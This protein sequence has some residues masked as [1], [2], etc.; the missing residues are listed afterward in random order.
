MTRKRKTTKRRN[1]RGKHLA[2]ATAAMN[3]QYEAILRSERKRGVPL[4]EAKRIAAATVRA[5]AK[6]NPIRR[7]EIKI[8]AVSSLRAFPIHKQ[9]TIPKSEKKIVS[10][11]LIGKVLT[12]V[13]SPLGNAKDS[14]G[15]IWFVNWYATVHGVSSNPKR[16][17]CNKAPSISEADISKLSPKAQAQLRAQLGKVEEKERDAETPAQKKSAEKARRSWLSRLGTRLRVIGQTSRRKVSARDLSKCKRRTVK[18]RA[19][20]ETDAIAK[21][22]AQLGSGYDDF[23]V[24]NPRPARRKVNG[25]YVDLIIRGKAKK[26]PQGWRLA[27]KT[28]EQGRGTVKVASGYYLDRHTGLVFAKRERNP[29][30]RGGRRA[31]AARKHM[32]KRGVYIV[33]WRA[34]KGKAHGD[35]V[36][37]FRTWE[38]TKAYMQREGAAH[39]DRKY[40]QEFVSWLH[41][42]RPETRNP[43]PKELRREFAG[44]VGPG[45][46]LY[47]PSHTPHGLAKLGKLVSIETEEGTIKPVH[48]SAWLCAD[49]RGRLHI[50]SVSGANIYNGPRRSFG[51]V[52]RI[53]YDESKPHL[54]YASPIIWTHKMAEGGGVRPKLYADGEGGLV[55]KG[56]SYQIRR[57]GIVG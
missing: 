51:H 19:R 12:K 9:F 36:A 18:V 22:R 29:N 37:R 48:G 47:F 40:T 28:F 6:K 49:K 7:H 13:D 54:G 11:Y 25:K 46:D 57:E 44:R 2:G 34:L 52:K 10:Q 26:T 4:K 35:D 1:P 33:Y 56:G 23:K 53:E 42:L 50:G 24:M 45:A 41:D 30:I 20:H 21:A 3:R 39:P 43:S 16:R 5:R 31:A 8:P 38:E 17:R 32:S 55:F 27:G 14:N 15:D